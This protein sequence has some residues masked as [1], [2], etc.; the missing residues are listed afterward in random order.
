MNISGSAIIYRV[1]NVLLSRQQTPND[2]TTWLIVAEGEAI[3][4][5]W[6]NPRL[7]PYSFMQPPKDDIWNFTFVADAPDGNVPQV[8]TSIRVEYL[9]G[10]FEVFDGAR[11]HAATNS[12]ESTIR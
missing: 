4:S 12:M 1:T 5:G 7:I 10:M 2:G 9:M 3:S 8:I 6:T 11:V